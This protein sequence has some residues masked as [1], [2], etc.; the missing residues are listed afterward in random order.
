[1]CVGYKSISVQ[2]NMVALLFINI[3]MPL[4]TDELQE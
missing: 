2:A 1:M 3:K 4:S